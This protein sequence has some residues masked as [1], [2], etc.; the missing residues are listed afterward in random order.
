MNELSDFR[1]LRRS[2][3]PSRGSAHGKAKASVGDE[4]N[5]I[6][7]LNCAARKDTSVSVF[8][9]EYDDQLWKSNA[10]EQSF[11]IFGKIKLNGDALDSC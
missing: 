4:R 3:W 7:S 6:R 5:A 8:A 2:G 9:F 11:G 1:T 10:N